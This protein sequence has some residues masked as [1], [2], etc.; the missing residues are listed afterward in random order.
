MLF[1]QRPLTL[2]HVPA[3]K[4]AP[5]RT[6]GRYRRR[7][8]ALFARSFAA[9]LAAFACLTLA[10][11]V[12]A[13][14]P[15]IFL[16]THPANNTRNLAVTTETHV[17][18]YACVCDAAGNTYVAGSCMGNTFWGTNS[19]VSVGGYGNEDLALVKY[20]PTGEVLWV[21][22]ASGSY[23]EAGRALALDGAGGVYLAGMTTSGYLPFSTNVAAYGELDKVLFVLVRYDGNGNVLWATRGG[24][25]SVSPFAALNTANVWP[26]SLAVDSGGNPIVAG[27]FNGNPMF[28]GTRLPN[29]YNVNTVF[30]NGVV[31]TNR[32]Q[33]VGLITEDLFLAKFSPA[34]NLLWA[35]N[36][37]S[38]N[39]EFASGIALDSADNIY[40]AGAFKKGTTLGS[41]NYT[42]SSA[43]G[44]GP[45]L[46]KL[47]ANGA[48]VW[49]SNLSE[50]T[51]NNLGNAWSVVVDSANRPTVAF[52]TPTSPFRLG[53]DSF[54]NQISSPFFVISSGFAQFET[55]G[56]VR[57]MKRTPF[58]VTATVAGV[59]NSFGLTL[60]RDG[61]DNLYARSAS[62]AMT[63]A[64][65]FGKLG[66]HVLK[67]TA[68]GEPLW[69]NSVTP[70]AISFADR[71][72]I[73]PYAL[74]AIS[75]DATGRISVVASISGDS[76][77]TG[78]IGWTNITTAFTN[79]YGYNQLLYRMESN[80]VAVAPQ[81][82]NQPTNIVFQPPQ[83]FTNSPLLARA[84]PVADYRWY[85][86]SN[87]ATIRVSSNNLFSIPNGTTLAHITSYYCVASNL[88]QQTTS[89]VFIAQAKLALYPLTKAVT[90]VLIGGSTTFS[91]NATGTTA[92]TYQWRMNGTNLPG[93]V[94][95]TLVVNYPTIASGTNGYDV[96]A[97]N[98]YGCL[99]SAPPV[100]MMVKGFGTID[101]SFPLG[102]AG[103]QIVIEPG[104]NPL[105]GGRQLI[106]YTTNGSVV[107]NG[108][109]NPTPPAPGQV[110]FFYPAGI[111]GRGLNVG[112]NRDPDGKLVVGGHFTQ[113]STNGVT[114]PA[115]NRMVRFTA[116][117]TIDPTFNAGTGPA[118]NLD[119]GGEVL[120]TAV[121][122]LASGK[123]LVGGSFTSF[124]GVGRTNIVR[125]NEDG[126]VD[127]SFV[128][129]PFLKPQVSGAYFGI[130]AIAV[131]TNGGIVVAHQYLDV[132]TNLYRVCIAGLTTNGAADTAFNNNLPAV[133]AGGGLQGWGSYASGRSLAIQPDGK[134]L[135][136]GQFTI[137]V[138]P[139][140]DGLIRLNDDGTLDPS[141][142]YLSSGFNLIKAV[143]VQA[144]GKVLVGFQ[145][146]IV[147]LSSE[148]TVD[149]TFAPDIVFG[150][151]VL[152]G[153]AVDRDKIYVT[154]TFGLYRLFGALPAPAVTSPTF[155]AGT[156]VRLPNGQFGFTTCGQNGQTL[157]IQASTNLVDWTSISTNPLVGACINFIDPQAALIPSRY[158]RV[159][160]L[161]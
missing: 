135:L 108:F 58:N 61:A 40:V 90:N 16:A 153:I 98:A 123:Y 17:E 101:P 88:V 147:R 151:D 42:N 56:T 70:V 37:G 97:C 73:D 5:T 46:A 36:H 122:C 80:Y 47:D 18:G 62:Y 1:H 35:T 63:N 54:T 92:F 14:A 110:S 6:T 68:S 67:L 79:G 96:I 116:D 21:R 118:P 3:S 154:G 28:G 158:Y 104:G 53:A 129:P 27:R 130:G 39:V 7:F 140:Y 19:I 69:T 76:T 84:W 31:L 32:E 41:A 117:G 136:A 102:A 49:S 9:T 115:L 20:S 107:T 75:L 48:V 4:Q 51:N 65:S 109:Y 128:P 105:V 99:T 82:L 30:T 112:F 81:F 60:T 66:I 127:L 25:W 38:T 120:V 13:Q 52:T 59:P 161:P 119:N 2:S 83:G 111:S 148:G 156:A 100:T 144:D 50:P 133:P 141:F 78:F 94:N 57:W 89:T 24:S 138:A 131:R 157:V 152:E 106:R 142:R 143:A 86:I 77:A 74:P 126:S 23:K 91:V 43:S 71:T 159:F 113:L 95:P 134:I 72:A 55:N 145:Q 155:S 45:F 146:A 34:G 12:Q 103:R 29:I 15:E 139:N 93:A 124:N 26:S 33:T 125:L 44:S 8:P 150:G 10:P 11:E 87:G 149:P 137:N 160:V 132:G 85:M 114:G 121:V 22:K 64:N